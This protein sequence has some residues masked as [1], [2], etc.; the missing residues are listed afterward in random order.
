MTFEEIAKTTVQGYCRDTWGSIWGYIG[1]RISNAEGSQWG[2]YTKDY[3]IV[4]ECRSH[5]TT[6]KSRPGEQRVLNLGE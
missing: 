3:N 5:P 4:L 1:L 2:S 6:R